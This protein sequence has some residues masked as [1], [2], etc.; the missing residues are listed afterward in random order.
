MRCE[1]RLLALDLRWMGMDAFDPEPSMVG[2]K[3]DHRRFI[4]VGQEEE[5]TYSNPIYS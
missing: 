2:S 3:Q 4:L 5:H 1:P